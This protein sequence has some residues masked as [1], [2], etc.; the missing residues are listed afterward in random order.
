[1]KITD[2]R[3]E[4][5]RIPMKHTFKVAF[6]EIDESVNVLVKLQ[7]EEGLCGYGE[8]AP[9]APV[10]GE[11]VESVLAALSLFRQ[12]LIGR[13]ALDIVGVHAMMDKLM[14][15]NTSAKCAVDIALHDLLGKALGQPL[16]KVLGGGCAMVENDFTIGI[17]TPENMAK[18]ALDYAKAGFRILKV[19]AGISPEEDIQALTLI[20]EA[21]GKDIRLRVDANQGYDAATAVS[22][23]ERMVPLGVEAVEQCLPY[24]D[25]AG[26][27]WVRNHVKGIKIMVDESLHSPHD[28]FS[29]CSQ[30]A[31]DIM[32]IK[33]MKCGGLYPA[34]KIDAIGEAAGVTCMVGCMLE[35]KV[36]ITAG[37]SLVAARRNITEADCDSFLYSK[38]PEMGMPGGFTFDGGT[39]TLSG[40]PGLGLDINF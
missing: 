17:D 19:K 38:D 21:V 34:L 9:F 31:A 32:N 15:H 25:V 27:A 35:T 36:A 16:Y 28:A 10:T 13:D 26:S 5:V 6:A 4:V 8:A 29:I 3:T 1:M 2:L 7:T 37:I 39:F 23:L 12:G 18:E 11:S 20:R 24:W 33:L 40:K 22:T 30:G 14:L